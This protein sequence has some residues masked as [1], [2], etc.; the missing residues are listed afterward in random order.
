M[1]LTNSGFDGTVT[2]AAWAQMSALTDVDSVESSAAWAITQGTGRQVSTAAHSGYAFAKGVLSKDT[3]PILTSLSTPV[4]GQW[5]LLARH[6]DWSTNA[7]TVVAL[8]HTTTTTTVPT[9]PPGTYPTMD[10]SPGVL[11]DQKLGWAWVRSTDTTVTLFDLRKLSAESRVVA[12][13]AD[14]YH[15]ADDAA[16]NAQVGMS[17]GNQ[18]FQEDTND[19]W[20]YLFGGWKVWHR[21][22]K[23]FSPNFAGFA[24]GN[25]SYLERTH[26]IVAGTT[27]SLAMTIQ[28]GS[29]STQSGTF[30]FQGPWSSAYQGS[31]VKIVGNWGHYDS[32][33]GVA[34]FGLVKVNS[35]NYSLLETPAGMAGSSDILS[36]TIN[37]LTALQSA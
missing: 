36:I 20:K 10:N 32:S 6:M 14:S 27:A 22:S 13:E 1:A 17:N 5:F 4:N 9:A 23:S 3:G 21:V 11:Y 31:G 2:E 26:S 24:L 8:A 30:V 28:M 33:S 16:R 25:G 18:G 12:L 34:S 37:D 29:T 7:V 15:W 19:T 35:S